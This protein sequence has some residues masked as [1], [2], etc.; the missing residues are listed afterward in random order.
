MEI[1]SWLMGLDRGPDS[2]G[3]SKESSEWI[4]PGGPRGLW[5][6]WE[7]AGTSIFGPTKHVQ[8][9]SPLFHGGWSLTSSTA[10]GGLAG[11]P[12]VIWLEGEE[13]SLFSERAGG[14]SLSLRLSESLVPMTKRE[15]EKGTKPQRPSA[16]KVHKSALIGYITQQ[17]E[18]TRNLVAVNP[19]QLSSS[20]LASR[21]LARWISAQTFSSSA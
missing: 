2:P 3:I 6:L 1:R 5:H 20:S 12:L 10:V 21:L 7:S 17:A 8:R 14:L 16:V 4:C 18:S 19:R 9:A 11:D 15:R 13:R